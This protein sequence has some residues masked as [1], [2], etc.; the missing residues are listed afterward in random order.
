MPESDHADHLL[1]AKVDSARDNIRRGYIRAARAEL[2]ELRDKH[3][4][5][6]ASLEFRI[7][8]NLGSCALAEEDRDCASA[9]FDEAYSLQPDNPKGIANAALAAHLRKNHNRAVEFARRARELDS[10][11][12]QA[13]AV[14]LRELW[15]TGKTK[16]LECLVSSEEWLT[17][18]QQC[19]LILTAIRIEQSRLEE[20]L[21]IC[22]ALIEAEPEFADTQLAFA[23]CIVSIAQASRLSTILTEVGQSLSEA[24]AT[25]TKAIKHFQQ[26]D[27]RCRYNHALVIRAGIRALLNQKEEAFQDLDSVLSNDPTHAEATYIKSLL[28]LGENRPDEARPVAGGC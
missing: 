25:A 28:L 10:E 5:I 3:R 2:L 15:E 11:N 4:A 23:E 7:V 13:T 22:S 6:R 20:A 26:T 17:R 24:L 18:D 16:E 27:L 21:T 12:P 9:F 1:V 19:G 8:T 14:L